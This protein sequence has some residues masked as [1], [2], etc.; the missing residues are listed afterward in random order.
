MKTQAKKVGNTWFTEDSEYGV[1][2]TSSG[3]CVT[4]GDGSYADFLDREEAEEAAELLAKGE[5]NDSDYEW[6]SE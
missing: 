4:R 3:A 5:K 6:K 1:R 2:D